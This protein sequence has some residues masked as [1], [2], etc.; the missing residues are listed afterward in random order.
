MFKRILI[1]AV[2]IIL[3]SALYADE[4]SLEDFL[5]LVEKNSKDLMLAK[6]EKNIAEAN[7]KEARSTALPKVFSELTYQRF[8]NDKYDD[9]AAE[10]ENGLAMV[11][12]KVSKDNGYS[13]NAVI[14]QTLFS[15]SAFN[16]I[17]A[18]R[19][20]AGLTDVAYDAAY[21]Q[22]ITAAKKLYYQTL[23]LEKV[24]KVNEASQ[25][26]AEENYQNIKKKYESGVVSEFQ[27][28]QAEVRWKNLIPETEKSKRNYELALNNLKNLAGIPIEEEAKF[29][30]DLNKYPEM[31]PKKDLENVLKKR[32][33]F[34][35]LRWEAKLRETNIHYEKAGYYPDL[36]AN[37]IYNYAAYS[38]ELK[39]ENEDKNFLLEL[40]LSIPIYTGGYT[41]A[42][43][44]KAKIELKKTQIK[45]NKMK[46][47]IYNSLE[48]IY[49]RLSEAEKRLESSNSTLDA[50]QRA[51]N[52]AEVSADNG[53]A[54][55]LE[56]KDARIL[57]DQA[58]LGRY[59][60]VLDYITAYFDYEYASGE[61]EK[62]LE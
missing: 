24:W 58:Q 48:N 2:I 18:A 55:Q 44:Q 56:L 15:V 4:Y 26:N 57:L 16:A 52:I 29:L 14:N 23:L 11:N 60:A 34:N 7:K 53:L 21:E 39:F 8:F 30:G 38:D 13:M 37:L 45:M 22:I 40:K 31:P 19:Q 20:Y 49:L 25:Q 1:C 50:A 3:N 54:T 12:A 27:L 28:L 35:A 36:Q 47:D 51:F 62:I 6:E 46:E 61:V 43:V 33:D 5:S 9:V 42:Q 59:A 41:S 10:T 17:K 32:S